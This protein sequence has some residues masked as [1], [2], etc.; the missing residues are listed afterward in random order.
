MHLIC[1]SYTDNGETNQPRVYGSTV[2]PVSLTA[3]GLI[4][5]TTLLCATYG[6]STKLHNVEYLYDADQL[7]PVHSKYRYWVCFAICF[8]NKVD[9]RSTFVNQGRPIQ[10][11]E[12]IRELE[13]WVK[14]VATADGLPLT[15]HVRVAITACK[16]AG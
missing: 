16:P 8:D 6:N 7:H 15:G 2:A 12:E 14:T 5:L 4:E 1:F 11:L 13:E 3:A 9:I 10:T